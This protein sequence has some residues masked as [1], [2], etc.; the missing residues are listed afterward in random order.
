MQG[1][2]IVERGA[3]LVDAGAELNCDV[4]TP[5]REYELGMNVENPD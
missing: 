1:A 4:R 3:V 2:F 5:F